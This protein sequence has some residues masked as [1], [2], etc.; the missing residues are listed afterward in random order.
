MVLSYHKSMNTSNKKKAIAIVSDFNFL[1]KNLNRFYTELREVGNYKGEIVIIT[2]Y[3]CPTFLFKIIN[4]KNNIKVLRFF[5]IKFRKD[6]QVNLKSLNTY[7]EPNR[8]KNKSF[9]WHKLHLFD[10]KLKDWNYIFYLD[11]NM[12]IHFDMTTILDISPV[13][14]LLAR[15]D[16]FPDYDRCLETQFD[17][18]H[19]LYDELAKTYNLKVNNYFQT[20]IMYY[21]TDIIQQ[22]TKQSIVD[23][24]ESFP[25]SITNE[26]G[27]L[28]LYFHLTKNLYEEIP[29]EIGD[30]V[31]YF[32]WKLK[33]KKVI[34]TKANKTFD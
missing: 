15:A 7:P 33:N 16:S 6:V 12:K 5:K 8:H 1:R 18:T 4:K 32:Y 34:I 11:I 30:F 3:F 27:I 21:D 9:Q 14:K 2:T 24:V 13:N 23:I 28:N 22:D 17:K 29:S 31:T 19:P 26:Q 25:I 20:G 10:K